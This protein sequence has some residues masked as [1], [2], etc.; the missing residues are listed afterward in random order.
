M[1]FSFKIGY[2]SFYFYLFA[3]YMPPFFYLI[4]PYKLKWLGV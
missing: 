2:R 3:Y 1:K 4:K